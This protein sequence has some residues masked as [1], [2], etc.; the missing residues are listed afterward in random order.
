MEDTAAALPPLRHRLWV[1]KAQG[2]DVQGAEGVL[3]AAKRAV[4]TDCTA[5]VISA[6]ANTPGRADALGSQGLRVILQTGSCL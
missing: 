3:V 4:I 1:P 5:A 2:A 6:A